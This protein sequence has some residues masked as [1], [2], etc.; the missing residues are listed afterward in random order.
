MIGTTPQP[1]ATSSWF[2]TVRAHP[3]A[4]L[5]VVQLLGI[6]VYPFLGSAPVGR[7]VFSTFALVVL[8]IAVMAIRLTPALSWVAALIGVPVVVL[9]ICEA[10]LPD[11]TDIALWSAVFHAVFYFYTAYALIRYMFSDN[12]VT[13]DEVF[14]TG[15]T[16]TVLAWAFAY[17]YAATQLVWPDSF[18]AAVNT[19]DPRSWT[20][21]LF[22]SVTTLTSTGLSDI[23]PIRPHA[24]SFVMIEQIAGMLY[25][26]LVVARIMALLSA[27]AARLGVS[28]EE[29]RAEAS[30]LDPSDDPTG[31]SEPDG[32]PS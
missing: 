15:A 2:R 3:S 29:L 5:L 24:R 14:A 19:A 6:I 31:G 10:A 30:I 26:A 28:H 22:L 23:A 13:T 11:N 1:P 17:V 16:F 25:L 20:E 12:V 7:A 27:R 21:L 8:V 18:N 32:A 4:V 9:T